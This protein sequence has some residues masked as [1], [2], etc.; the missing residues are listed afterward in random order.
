MEGGNLLT[1]MPAW[2]RPMDSGCLWQESDLPF[3]MPACILF[4]HGSPVCGCRLLEANHQ[5]RTRLDSQVWDWPHTLLQAFPHKRGWMGARGG[6]L[7][8]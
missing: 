7:L 5:A 6:P 2:C 8:P 1:V 3:C 4:L